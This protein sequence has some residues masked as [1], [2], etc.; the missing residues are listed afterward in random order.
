M[1]NRG[2]LS[3]GS[4][5]YEWLIDSVRKTTATMRD[6]TP[7][8]SITLTLAWVY[9]PGSH[10]VRIN[11][12]PQN[13]IAEVSEQNNSIEDQ[14][15][16]LAVGFWVEQSV[17]DWFNIHQVE[18]GLGSV[19]WDDWAQRQLKTWNEVFAA[20]IHPLTPD[21]V[22]ERV[23]L[24]KVTII[25]DGN[26]PDCPD[27]PVPEDPTVDL[28][29]EF[30]SE[31]VGVASGHSCAELNFYMNHPEFQQVEPPLLHEMSHARYLVDLY[32]LNMHVNNAA[33]ANAVNSTE[34]RSLTMDRDVET[35]LDFPLP[36]PLVVDGEFVICQSKKGASFTGCSRR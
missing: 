17:Y 20:A 26:W 15:N 4:F 16:A 23:R 30:P 32:G 2:G 34:S 18:L 28:V 35:D 22:L 9:Q 33:L 25:P 8:Q 29:W 10:L 27:G 31:L 24:D 11:L 21:G 7:G 13:L 19:S 6:L 12:D 14:T 3:T 1:A 36:T 5:T